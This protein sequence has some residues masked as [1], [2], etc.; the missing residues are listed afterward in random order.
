MNA[1]MNVY[2]TAKF[3]VKSDKLNEAIN[4]IKGLTTETTQNEK[5]CI[6]YYY[7]QNTTNPYEFTSYEIWENESEESKHWE[8]TYV[9]KAIIEMPNLLESNPEIIKWKAIL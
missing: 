4:L 1:S 3:T 6:A 2:V 5:G 9:Q 7:L 8:T